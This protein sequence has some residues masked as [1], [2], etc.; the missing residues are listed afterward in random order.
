[1][2]TDMHVFHK[3]QWKSKEAEYLLKTLSFPH[4]PQVFPQGFSTGGVNCGYSIL[5]HI[6]RNDTVRAVSH[7]FADCVFCH[8]SNFVQKLPP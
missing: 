5:V 7:F 8:G 4:S 1:M 6:K 2:Q 3:E